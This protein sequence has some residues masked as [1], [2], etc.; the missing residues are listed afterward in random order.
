[1]IGQEEED[2]EVGLGA[3]CGFGLDGTNVPSGRTSYDWSV[4]LKT[5]EAGPGTLTAILYEKSEEPGDPDL[6][7]G[8]GHAQRDSGS[9]S[10]ADPDR[11]AD[12][13]GH[14]D[15]DTPAAAADRHADA[16]TH[17]DTDA[18][19]HADQDANAHAHQDANTHAHQDATPTPTPLPAPMG[20]VRIAGLS[21]NLVL[22]SFY[23][24]TVEA[25]NLS[26]SL[27]HRLSVGASN[28]NVGFEPGSAPPE[29][30][31]VAALGNSCGV[32]FREEDV[33]SGQTSYSW[34]VALLRAAR[35]GE[36]E[37]GERRRQR[38]SR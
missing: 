13:N 16:H 23:Y 7:L 34:G 22:G 37:R 1:M 19:S 21:S 3:N 30:N 9:N 32:S 31:P 17:Q 35:A 26:A 29:E 5:C 38:R 27:Q 15:P 25:S 8:Q 36:P 6:E 20:S 18:D 10:H 4:T 2:G 24:F 11:H 33:P 14:A 28:G 12:A